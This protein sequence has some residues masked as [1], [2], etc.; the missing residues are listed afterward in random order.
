MRIDWKSLK[1]FIDDTKLYKIINYVELDT[2]YY[3]WILYEG[4]T[5]SSSLDKGSVD[6]EDF[7]KNY[8]PL[9]ILKNDLAPDGVKF[10]RSMLVYVKRL[11]HCLFTKF[12][13]SS[14]IS[15]D[16]TGF[17]TMRMR[18]S[19]KQ[20][21]EDPSQAV[22]TEIDFCLGVGV[23]CSLYGGSIEIIEDFDSEIVVNAIM[24]PDIPAEYGGSIYFIRNM[25]IYKKTNQVVSR[26]SPNAGDITTYGIPGINVLR[27][28]LKHDVG[29]QRQIQIE[30]RYFV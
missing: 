24:A 16:E 8:K 30:F 17:I 27:M 19:Q 15:N 11:Y 22:Y 12:T 7:V 10:T 2:S 4:E 6:C 18:D 25:I 23:D 26:I 5:F 3:V 28:Q 29:L 14:T 9:A 13:T 20:I 21:T 1:K